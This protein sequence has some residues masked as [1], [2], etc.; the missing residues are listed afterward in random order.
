MKAFQIDVLIMQNNN[1]HMGGYV[2]YFTD[3]PAT[4]GYPITVIFPGDDLMSVIQQG[5]MGQL[6]QLPP[7][8]DGLRRGVKQ[9]MTT[10]V[11]VNAPYTLRYDAEM[12]EKTGYARA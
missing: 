6:T 7:E 5:P 3:Q 12:A 10:S 11:F 4:N 9:V 2:R 8:G 1:D